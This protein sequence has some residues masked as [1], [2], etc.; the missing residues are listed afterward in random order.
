[1]RAETYNSP[2]MNNLNN[3]VLVHTRMVKFRLQKYWFPFQIFVSHKPKDTEFFHA[4]K[5]CFIP[6]A[7]YERTQTFLSK[8]RHYVVQKAETVLLRDVCEVDFMSLLIVWLSLIQCLQI[9]SVKIQVLG[10]DVNQWLISTAPDISMVYWSI[11]VVKSNW[12]LHFL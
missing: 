5:Q 7:V 11:C 10:L 1:M 6:E 4:S 2:Q 3:K 9:L 8:I 12:I